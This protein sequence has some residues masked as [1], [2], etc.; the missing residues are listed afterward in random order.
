MPSSYYLAWKLVHIIPSHG[1]LKAESTQW[2][3]SDYINENFLIKFTI[4]SN[5]ENGADMTESFHMQ[6]QC[7]LVRR[8]KL[9]DKITSAT[10]KEII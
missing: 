4:Q 6:L 2:L 8:E 5:D 9:C 7:C 1:E 3:N 10:V